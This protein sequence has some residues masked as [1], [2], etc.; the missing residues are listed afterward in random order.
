MSTVVIPSYLYIYI[1]NIINQRY[2]FNKHAIRLQIDLTRHFAPRL[3]LLASKRISSE[4]VIR[5][6]ED[7]ECRS[8]LESFLTK[9]FAEESFNFY[10]EVTEFK[11]I[12]KD[13]IR[14]ASN[15]LFGKFVKQGSEQQINVPAHMV[16]TCKVRVC[17]LRPFSVIFNPHLSNIHTTIT[18]YFYTLLLLLLTLSPHRQN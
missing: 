10:T 3:A 11:E 7:S 1:I 8:L 18:H 4:T 16:K 13:K 15:K 5:V 14:E 17:A 6:L 9:E 12:Q 2:L